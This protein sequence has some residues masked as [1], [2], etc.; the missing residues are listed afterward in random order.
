M[1]SLIH[2][3]C[4]IDAGAPKEIPPPEKIVPGIPS[5]S[6]MATP[7]ASD[8]QVASTS[9]MEMSN[10]SMPDISEEDVLQMDTPGF[11]LGKDRCGTT[12]IEF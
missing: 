7:T 6:L 8:Q 1:Y 11:Y 10:M 4:V 5:A 3:D 2:D 12:K 9:N